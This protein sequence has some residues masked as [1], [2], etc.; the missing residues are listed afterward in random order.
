MQ[1]KQCISMK[2]VLSI[3][4][5]LFVLYSCQN[6]NKKGDTL[7]LQSENMNADNTTV[8]DINVEDHDF[9]QLGTVLRASAYVKLSPEP[10]LSTIKETRIENERIYIHDVM[11]RL[12]CYDMEG[13]VVYQIDAKGAGP[14]EYVNINSFVINNHTKELVIYDNLK[15][16]LLYY[17]LPNGKYIKNRKVL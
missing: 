2:K 9:Q 15:L 4:L 13:K 11:S 10:L 12:I 5:I 17:D 16:S 14:G 8:I 6:A 3:L 1:K 7:I